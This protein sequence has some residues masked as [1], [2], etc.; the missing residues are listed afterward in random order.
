MTITIQLDEGTCS[1]LALYA[2]KRGLGWGEA[3]GEMLAKCEGDYNVAPITAPP[4][5]AT[6]QTLNP[7]D[8]IYHLADGSPVSERECQDAIIAAKAATVRIHYADGGVKDKQWRAENL[9]E[10]S[11]L[12]GNLKTGYLRNWRDRGIVKAEVFAGGAE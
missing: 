4:K 9:Q 6:A 3:I 11:Y 12:R 8:I 7:P 1:R 5:P 10:H 2:T